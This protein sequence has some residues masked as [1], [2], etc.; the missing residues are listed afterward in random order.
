MR[1]ETGY[2]S[3][4]PA[5]DFIRHLV[6]EAAHFLPAQGPIGVFIHHNTLHAFQHLPFDEAVKAAGELYGAQ[7]YLSE[8]D[9]RQ[10]L[11]AGRIKVEDI[12]AVLWREPDATVWDGLRRNE[13]RRRILLEDL[14]RFQPE[15]VL[16][17]LEQGGLLD[18]D[19]AKPLF[20]HCLRLI[21]AE[22][23]EPAAPARPRDGI[24][25]QSGIDIDE[26]VN[27]WMIRLC[28]AF[29]DQGVAY[30][31]M[32]NREGGF[33][34]AAVTLL[35]HQAAPL[36]AELATLP[37]RCLEAERFWSPEDVIQWALTQMGVAETG[38]AEAIKAE[39][40]ALPGWAGMMHCLEREPELAPH[41]AV[42]ASLMEF[43]A[44]R[45]LLT[46]AA[47]DSQCEVLADWKQGR[48]AGPDPFCVRMA[49][50]ATLFEAARKLEI[51]VERLPE[52]SAE[53]E[54]FT[55]LERRRILHLAYERRHERE[56][57]V[58]LQ[59]H[60]RTAR[61]TPPRRLA[62]QVFFCLDEREE[63][64]RRHLEEVAPDVETF[65]AAGFYGVAMSFQ[66]VDDAVE[67]SLCPVVVKPAHAVKERPAA[68]H[69]GSYARRVRLRRLWALAVRH[70]TISSRTIVRGWIGTSVLGLFNLA[71]L[72]ARILSP[73]QYARLVKWVNA[74]ILPELRTELAFQRRGDEDSEGTFELLQGFTVEEKADRVAAVLAN[75]GLMRG[76]ARLVVL[77]G[78][79]STSINNP[80]ESAYNCG[81]CGGWRGGP[82]ARLF[83]AM[84]NRPEVRLK[85]R[86]RGIVIPEDTRFVGG[87][88]DTCTDA[89]EFYDL[90][91]L[92]ISH[93]REM[94]HLRASLEE[95]RARNARERA[96]RF[97]GGHGL[98]VSSGLRHVE[99]RSEHLAEARP[100]YGHS[101]NAVCI[102][103][104]RDW[105]RGVFLDRRAFLASYD[106]AQDPQDK[107]LAAQLEAAVPVCAGIN[108]EYYFSRVDNE[109]YGCGTKLPHNVAS[110]LGVMNGYESDLR[111]G[112][113]WQMVEIHEPVRILFAIEST[114]ERIEKTFRANPLL[115][116]FLSNEWIR[117]A[118]I[119]PYNGNIDVYRAGIWEPLEGGEEGLG[120]ARSSAE[121]F[122]GRSEHLGI[123]RIETARV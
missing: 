99:E 91:D 5:A 108:L 67:A 102:L 104:R 18:S 96:R 54:R 74:R 120:R 48:A 41:Q 78:H 31:P 7:P 10:A 15:T 111:T 50:V 71:P 110:L 83:A 107:A 34:V 61:H 47:V 32:P 8:A 58:P 82:S 79:G 60:L 3:S 52:L 106:M 30:W 66:G 17:D 117:V 94:R 64:M 92:P 116:E 86:S 85:L 122:K 24:L 105:T 121:W 76:M 36:P 90:H 39:L 46:L 16:W 11:A 43:L 84:A 27:P 23:P 29:L 44:V 25:A 115:W 101:S 56:I 49:R 45:M 63:S 42:S 65:G 59:K 57:L 114:P 112:L 100:E 28:G 80:H 62:A 51:P 123:A 89:V 97:D 1:P 81:A 70:W 98:D 118:A 37:K 55:E 12:G 73:L 6:E 77:L 40:L 69:W 2:L 109:K 19:E 53:L 75:A 4:I 88:H 72:S 87:T 21:P 113:T 119:N 9:Y 26:F 33:Y 14:R 13:L 20:Q 103:G 22:E 35:A 68:G 38:W 95:A 93:E